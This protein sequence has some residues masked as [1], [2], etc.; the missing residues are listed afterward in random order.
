[1]KILLIDTYYPAFLSDFWKNNSKL[2]KANYKIQLKALLNQYFGTSDFYSK[3][4]I[5]LGYQA[6]DVIA[7]DEILQ[8]QWAKENGLNLGK[9][10]IIDRLRSLPL[11]N[12]VI[13]NPEWL[14]KIVLEQVKKTRPDVVYMQNLSVLNPKTLKAIK[15]YSFLVG[16]IAS[17][18]PPEGSIK[19]FDLILTSFPHFVKRFREMGINSEYLKIGFEPRVLKKIGKVQKKY[20][21]TFVGGFTPQHS[22]ATRILENA[23]KK[24]KIDVWGRGVEFLSSSSPLR[25]HY[26]GEAWGLEMYKI[27]AQSRITLNRHISTSENY[28]NNMRLFEATGMGAT[29]VTDNKKNIKDLFKVGD[30]VVVYNNSGDLV[31]KIK[32]YLENGGEATKIAK[33]GQ[34][35]TLEDYTYLLRMKELDKIIGKYFVK[36]GLV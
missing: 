25:K 15:K 10:G 11:A 31:E 32:Y 34:K 24:V 4:L 27:L 18:M 8:R 5:K 1:M 3:N 17:P 20:D 16:Q 36:K 33:N 6:E 7:N 12:R 2:E 14:Q 30:E 21:V 19:E 9:T 23:A 28:A 13:G 29:L 22:K 26:H 35:R